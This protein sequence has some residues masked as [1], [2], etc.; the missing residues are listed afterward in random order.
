MARGAFASLAER[1]DPNSANGGMF[2]GL[3][4]AVVKVS[5]GADI[6]GFATAVEVAIAVHR[7]IFR[8]KLPM[9]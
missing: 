9:I 5:G 7:L 8:R 2:L 3:N 4:G 1:M 6:A